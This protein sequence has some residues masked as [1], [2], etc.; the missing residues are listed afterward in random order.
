MTIFFIVL[1]TVLLAL[2]LV[3]SFRKKPAPDN[4][5]AWLDLLPEPAQPRSPEEVAEA[6]RAYMEDFTCIMLADSRTQQFIGN[7]KV[8]EMGRMPPKSSNK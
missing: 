7:V 2:L 5:L 4:P 6:N 1:P 3:Y 8:G